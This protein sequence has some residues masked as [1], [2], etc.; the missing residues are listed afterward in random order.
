VAYLPHRTA[1]ERCRG[2]IVCKCLSRQVARR[3]QRHHHVVFDT[4]ATE[5]HQAIDCGPLELPG[6]RRCT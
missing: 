3:F 2:S 4:N 1:D 5:R 6:Q